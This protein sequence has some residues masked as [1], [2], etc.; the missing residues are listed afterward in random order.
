MARGNNL[1]DGATKEAAKGTFMEAAVGLWQRPR[2]AGGAAL[3]S[4]TV[5]TRRPGGLVEGTR[6][7]AGNFEKPKVVTGWRGT[8][9][10]GVVNSQ[11]WGTSKTNETGI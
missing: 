7:H 2:W 3:R 9:G 10:A 8:P 4:S 5:G 11:G 1:A 6:R